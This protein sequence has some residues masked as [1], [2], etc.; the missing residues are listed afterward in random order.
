[1]RWM[2]ALVEMTAG[3]GVR[4]HDRG[5]RVFPSTGRSVAKRGPLRAADKR[6]PAQNRFMHAMG[7]RK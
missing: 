4:L 6:A 7:K 3:G 2:S 5:R 1:M